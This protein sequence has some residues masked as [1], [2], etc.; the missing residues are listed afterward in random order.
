[1]QHSWLRKLENDSSILVCGFCQQNHD[2]HCAESSAAPSS[3]TAQ[4]QIRTPSSSLVSQAVNL[5]NPTAWLTSC[6]PLKKEDVS[7]DIGD[8]EAEVE[9][10]NEGTPLLGT[11]DGEEPVVVT[12]DDAEEVVVKKKGKKKG[13]QVIKVQE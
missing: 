10:P 8:I 9:A 7:K 13:K 12:H 2:L 4:N 6:I 1:M 3:S 5:P 11:T